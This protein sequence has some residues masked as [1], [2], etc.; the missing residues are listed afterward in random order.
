VTRSA[1]ARPADQ[2]E[3]IIARAAVAQPAHKAR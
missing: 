1:G 3:A 2:I